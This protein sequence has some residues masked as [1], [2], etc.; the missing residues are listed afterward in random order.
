M[1]WTK[2][3]LMAATA[4]GA[5]ALLAGASQ[6]SAG[7]VFT[8]NPSSIPGVSSPSVTADTQQYSDNATVVLTPSG[9]GAN[10]TETG[11]L[12]IIGFQLSN[13]NVPAPGLNTTGGY[14]AYLLFQGAG[15]QST[16]TVTPAT[17]GMFTSLTF[18]M[19]VAPITG[20]LTFSNTDAQPTGIGATTEVATGSLIDSAVSAPL[21]F[22][23]ANTELTFNVLDPAFFSPQ[24]FY[25]LL[26]SQ[27]GTT[28]GE[29]RF[30]ADG[31]VINGGGGSGTY[32]RR[33]PE[34]ASL[35]LLGG[36]LFGLAMW[37]RRSRGA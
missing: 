14:A 32:A 33:V 8:Y 7:A 37:R 15:T 23:A 12:N 11:S 31:F 28:N 10:F 25:N 35:A 3:R 22:P 24:P 26:F 2:T 13:V 21:G 16:P 9:S 30:T 20:P 34:P 17:T 4:L 27:F 19:F 36:A 6:A 29:V 5:V 18:E 1:L